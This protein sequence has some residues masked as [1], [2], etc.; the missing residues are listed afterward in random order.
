MSRGEQKKIV[1]RCL[2]GAALAFVSAT[3][4]AQQQPSLDC[5]VFPLPDARLNWIAPSIAFN[6]L[7]MQ[8][9]EFDSKETPKS[10]LDFYRRE[11]RAS[12]THPGS[13][14]YPLDEWQVIATRREKCFYTVQV[15]ATGKDGSAGLL[16]MSRLPDPSQMREVGKHFP[17]MTGSQVVNDIDHFDPGKRGRTLFFTNEFSPDANADFYRRVLGG[18][19]WAIVAGNAMPAGNRNVYTMTLRRGA[20][21]TS[22]SIAR[23]GELTSVLVNMVDRP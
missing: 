18:E 9:R 2:A 22:M 7:P 12:K 8:I 11:W 20:A 21:E 4:T 23:T 16:G 14:E 5:P 19:G 15:K 17:M 1:W 6:G 13:I 10:I 3:A